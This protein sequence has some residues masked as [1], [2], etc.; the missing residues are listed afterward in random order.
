MSSSLAGTITHAFW[1]PMHV[2]HSHY[3]YISCT[4]THF[5]ASDLIQS[6]LGSS[7]TC[8]S[9]GSATFAALRSFLSF[10]RFFSRPVR[11][12]IE[13]F[14]SK[15]II[16]DMPLHFCL[17]VV[18]YL[19][20]S[21]FCDFSWFSLLLSDRRCCHDVVC[22]TIRSHHHSYAFFYHQSIREHTPIAL[23]CFHSLSSPFILTLF[24]SFLDLVIMSISYTTDNFF[25]FDMT[26]H[27]PDPSLTTYFLQ[28][29]NESSN[30]WR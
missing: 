15:T 12:Q 19:P 23:T 20:F 22:V 25:M 18:R 29:S 28:V 3:N 1:T 9:L 16:S 6:K 4:R 5:N 7:V 11:T 26:R 8:T 2:K 17:T 10:C 13:G 21:I 14:R 30:S 27:W 24:F